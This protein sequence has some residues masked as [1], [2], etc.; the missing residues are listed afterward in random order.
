MDTAGL[1][2]IGFT[3]K[4][5]AINT[6]ITGGFSGDLLSWVMANAKPGNCWFTIMS[7]LNSI[8]VATLVELSAI[9]FCDNVSLDEVIL[10]KAAETRINV[11][12]TELSVFEASIKFG[13]VFRKSIK[14]N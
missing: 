10:E 2:Q 3:Q 13:D 9:V 8:A 14:E 6:E 7:N 4:V 5:A 1:V 12:T 11:F